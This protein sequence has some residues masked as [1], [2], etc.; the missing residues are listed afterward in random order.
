MFDLGKADLTKYRD[1]SQKIFDILGKHFKNVEK[2]SIDEAYI[3]L[4]EAAVEYTSKDNEQQTELESD[5]FVVGTYAA[6]SLD[7][8]NSDGQSDQAAN[9]KAWLKNTVEV[10]EPN[11]N[12]RLLV[13]GA[14]LVQRVRREIFAS[15]GFHCSAGIAHNKTLA[16]LC[17]GINKP[18]RQ[19][20][21][22]LG[23]VQELYKRT[24][25]NKMYCF[26]F[27]IKIFEINKLN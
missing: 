27:S 12:E 1:A 5:S 23:A 4:T 10:S 2:A 21:L 18:N 17:A 22:P 15:L 14:C 8:N 26:V 6:P 24:P 11:S 16:K 13:A 25:I 19:T 3:D 9:L 7:D 20:I